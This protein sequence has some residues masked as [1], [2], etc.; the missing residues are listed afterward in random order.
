MADDAGQKSE[1]PS[2][3]RLSEAREKG[4]I[5][6]SREVNT[7]FMLVAS[8]LA[9]FVLGPS[10]MT[11]LALT[12]RQFIEQP[13]Q[14]AMDQGAL[15]QVLYDAFTT[16]ALIA[17]IPLA[18]LFAGGMIGPMLQA[19]FVISFEPLM[20]SL[21]KISPLAGLKRL[22]SLRSVIEF[23][24]GLLKLIVIGGVMTALLLP[25]LSGLEHFIGLDPISIMDDLRTLA[26]RT[27]GGA[28]GV[29]T[30]IAAGDFLYQRFEFMQKMRMSKQEVKEEF[31]QSEGDPV[32]RGRL[33]QLRMQRARRRMMQAVP[34]ADVVITNPTH[35][36]VA[37]QY[38]PATMAAPVVV[39]KGAD[40]I[41]LGHSHAGGTARHIDHRKPAIGAG[42]VRGGGGRPGDTARA[43]SGGCRNHLL[44]VPV[45]EP[46]RPALGSYRA[47]VAQGTKRMPSCGHER[48]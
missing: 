10:V 24:K 40:L 1:A 30:V 13:A 47:R 25:S 9:V 19:G 45:E 41:A 35:F 23:A 16:S 21:D 6:L 12:L 8:M 29:V 15:G 42:A 39:A 34:K 11:R 5:P 26:F 38:D 32:I 43:L 48:G 31:K 4:Q 37:M 44:R 2:G 27:A 46:H 28:V 20:P 36:A 7:W 33:R 17:A 18:V 3:K 22:F 14:M